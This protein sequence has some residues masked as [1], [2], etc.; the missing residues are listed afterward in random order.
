MSIETFSNFDLFVTSM[1]RQSDL[2]YDFA[3]VLYLEQRK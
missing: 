3:M 1:K 2:L